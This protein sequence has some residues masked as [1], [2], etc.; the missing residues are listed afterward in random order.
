MP[1][2]LLTR[3]RFVVDDR[4]DLADDLTDIAT[5]TGENI[6]EVEATLAQYYLKQILESLI[7]ATRIGR[8]TWPAPCPLTQLLTTSLSPTETFTDSQSLQTSAAT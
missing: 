7:L 2:I 8:R 4:K 3:Y 6:S 1:Q 5:S